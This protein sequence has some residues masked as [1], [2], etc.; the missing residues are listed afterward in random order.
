[1]RVLSPRFGLSRTRAGG[2][3]RDG[4]RPGGRAARRGRRGDP[5]RRR[6]RP[7]RGR[8]RRRRPRP[9]RR[10][11]RSRLLHGPSRRASRSRAGSPGRAAFPSSSSRR[12]APRRRL[13]PNLPTS[14]SSSTRGRG[15]VHGARRTAG[16]LAE[17]PTP[18]PR[19]EAV[20]AA[21]AEGVPVVDLALAGLPL[22]GAAAAHR[23]GAPDPAPSGGVVYGRPQRGRREAA[24]PGRG[25]RERPGRVRHDAR[26]ARGR[27]RRHRRARARGL[28]G[29]L[30]TR[31]LRGRDRRRA[32][33]QP[34]RDR[35]DGATS[36]ATSSAPSPRASSTSTRSRP[37]RSTGAS[38]IAVV[39]DGRGARIRRGRP[40]EEIYLEVRVS[41]RPARTFY[42][43]LGFRE[44]GRRTRYYLDGEDA[45]VLVLD[46][47]KTA[48][49]TA[50]MTKM[51]TRDPGLISR[52]DSRRWR[53]R[54]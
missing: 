38:G 53:C 2:R 27:P 11:L 50:R 41:N 47:R 46:M 18:R 3:G 12:S 1:M 15:E 48:S 13:F 5:E 44:A 34:G 19:E 39:P 17:W 49:L 25:R 32:P 14:T 22:A 29:P 42:A 28:P 7:R 31:V 21:A 45:L 4:P 16:R 23:G 20:A 24:A 33:L 40:V 10:P 51:Q 36:R 35:P 43:G 30:E 26:R 9:D 54:P 52:S 8:P 6:G 37:T